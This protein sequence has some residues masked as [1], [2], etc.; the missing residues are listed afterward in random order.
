MKRFYKFMGDM[1]PVILGILIALCINNWNENRADRKYLSKVM[2]SIDSELKENKEQLIEVIQEHRE[3][4]DTIDFYRNQELSIEEL[5]VKVEGI[6]G[7]AI[8]N[9]TWRALI[10]SRIELVDNETIL[11]MTDVDEE[12]ADMELKQDKLTQFLYTNLGSTNRDDKRLLR[13]IINDML[14]IELETLESHEKFL[15]LYEEKYH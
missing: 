13:M 6:R 1:I 15:E 3:L 12:K 8:K 7:T 5:L 2:A 11:T 9:H 4:L 10:N 14:S